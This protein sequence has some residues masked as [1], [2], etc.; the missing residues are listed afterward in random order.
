MPARPVALEDIYV[1]PRTPPVI[2][3]RGDRS[4]I[5]RIQLNGPDLLMGLQMGGIRRTHDDR[6][7]RSR[8]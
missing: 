6:R 1:V 7:N 8:A 4:Q 5:L 3:D 2:G